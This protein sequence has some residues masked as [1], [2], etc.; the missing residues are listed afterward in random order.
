VRSRGQRGQAA[1]ELALVLPLLALLALGLV[2]VALVVRDQVRV[3]FGAREGARQAAVE[4]DEGAVRRAV[5]ASTRLGA[6]RL[7]IDVGERGEP[8]SRVTVRVAY[9]APTDLPLVG[10]LVGDVH[11]EGL[12]TMR[13]ER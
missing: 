8:G 6:G 11:L 5:T 10:R 7:E 13:V 9:R 4:D 2:Q 3:T 12:A 1:V